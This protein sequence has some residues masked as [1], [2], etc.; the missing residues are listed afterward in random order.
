MRRILTAFILV[1][2]TGLFLAA[3][4]APFLA[5]Y[6]TDRQFRDHP[7][8]SPVSFSFDSPSG[9][10][11]PFPRLVRLASGKA[12]PE[13]QSIRF[14]VRGESYNWMGLQVDLHLFG[15]RDPEN[16]LFLLGTDALGRDQFSRL[17]YAIRFSLAVGLCGILLTILAGV[18][19]GVVAGYFGGWCDLLVMRVCD[20]FLSLPGLFLVLG[21]R[22]VLPLQL[23]LDYTFWMMILVFTLMGWGVVT[24]VVRGQVLTLKQRPYVLAA[25]TAGASNWYIISRHII[26]FTY[27][28]LFVQSVVFIPL[29]VLGEITLSFLGVGVQEPNASLGVLLNA[30]A[31]YSVA[32]RYPWLLWPV[33]VIAA[34]TF[35]FNLIA[36]E[37]RVRA[38]IAYR[39]L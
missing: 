28:Y 3:G 2:L 21:L 23:T 7:Y 32:G 15:S 14:F 13:V 30:A 25:R 6:A 24:R 39:W 4:L 18:T 19:L 29:F 31:S 36:D 26:P 37:I 17:L 5:P 11:L 8:R 27:D 16:P 22:A 34:M 20:L 12:A 9:G 10:F 38:K 35:G 1:G 33:F